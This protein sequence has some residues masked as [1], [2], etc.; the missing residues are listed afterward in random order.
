MTSTESRE[1]AAEC[2]AWTWIEAKQ[3]RPIR[4]F[5]PPPS[6]QRFDLEHHC[7]SCNNPPPPHLP[8]ALRSA[9]ETTACSE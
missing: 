9:V 6:Y 2:L 8:L 3:L 1:T 7:G 4:A 5:A